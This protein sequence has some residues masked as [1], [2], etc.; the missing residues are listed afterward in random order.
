MNA[1]VLSMSVLAAFAISAHALSGEAFSGQV[2]DEST[3]KPV[4]DAI[5]VLHW[6]GRWSK[7]FGESSGACYHVETAR[8][9]AQ[10]KF[11]TPAWKTRWQI[12]DLRLSREPMGLNVYKPGYAIAPTQPRWNDMHELHIA[13]FR[14]THQAYFDMVLAAP[15]WGCTQAGASGKNEYRLFKAMAEEARA[16]AETPKQHS[17]ARILGKLAEESL[18]NFDKS[19][20]YVGS[21][22]GVQN[23]D[24]RDAFKVEE[25]P[26]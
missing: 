19:T 8:T 21:G 20:H 22:D 10:G 1:K 15:G 17:T 26:Q 24:P 14:W 4:A 3:G 13:P 9:D 18:V 25:V 2:I 11:Q 16:L 6:N 12:E 7:I 5:V 23:V